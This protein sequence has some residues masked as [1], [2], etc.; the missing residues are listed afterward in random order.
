MS[1]SRGNV[2]NPLEIVEQYGTDVYRYFLLRE[3]TFGFD[4]TF[5]EEALIKRLN[6]D[7]ANDLGNLVYR[8]LSMVEKYCAGVVPLPEQRE[9][10]EAVLKENLSELS[11]KFDDC[12]ERLDFAS[13]LSLVWGLI[14]RANKYIEEF[15]PWNVAKDNDRKPELDTFLYNLLEVLRVVAVVLHPFIPQATHLIWQQMGMK[16]GLSKIPFSTICLWGVIEPGTTIAKDK[17][18]FP[19]IEF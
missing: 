13:A 14:N 2:I 11:Q 8:T 7:L 6:Y 3:V 12:M 10:P 15:A 9:C 4:G 5:S 1:K 17:P 19:R 16:E 18:L